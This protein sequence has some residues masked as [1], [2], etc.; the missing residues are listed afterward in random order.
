MDLIGDCYNTLTADLFIC[1]VLTSAPHCSSPVELNE[2]VQKIEAAGPRPNY[3]FKFN[4]NEDGKLHSKYLGDRYEPAIIIS[5]T[6]FIG[7]YYLFDGIIRDCVHP[8]YLFIDINTVKVLYY[9]TE[10]IKTDQPI[11]ITIDGASATESYNHRKYRTVH[12]NY[13]G[14]DFTLHDYIEGCDDPLL[15]FKFVD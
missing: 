11:Y 4:Y 15:P 6:R 7:R 14:I 3:M 9:S 12:N 8:F 5:N 10:R 1:S 13:T 2:F